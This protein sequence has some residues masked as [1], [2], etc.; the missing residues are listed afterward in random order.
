MSDIPLR[1]SRASPWLRPR[2][3]TEG[4]LRTPRLER[5]AAS[6]TAT[7][8]PTP[9]GA[10]RTSGRLRPPRHRRSP[11]RWRTASEARDGPALRRR[12]LSVRCED[13][14]SRPAFGQVGEPPTASA[15]TGSATDTRFGRPGQPEG[16]VGARSNPD[17]GKHR[18]PPKE[19]PSP[20]ETTPGRQRCARCAARPQRCRLFAPRIRPT[21]EGPAQGRRRLAA[22]VI[23]CSGAQGH[24]RWSRFCSQNLDETAAG[25]PQGRHPYP[26]GSNGAGGGPNHIGS[27]GNRWPS[28][29]R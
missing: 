2:R 28:K 12:P 16:R 5:A 22:A 26:H 27:Y 23:L 3:Q 8:Q 20:E 11:P 19:V 21:T 13:G 24:G 1:V 17:I 29:P 6:A 14:R 10:P 25:R 15:F 7:D 9:R 18:T 4:K